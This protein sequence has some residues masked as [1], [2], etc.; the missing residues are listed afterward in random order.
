LS[1]FVLEI[2]DAVI[3]SSIDAQPPFVLVAERRETT[4]RVRTASPL[5]KGTIRSRTRGIDK[6]AHKPAR[7]STCNVLYP[8]C[9][10]AIISVTVRG[11]SS[12]D[13]NTTLV[14]KSGSTSNSTARIVVMTAVGIEV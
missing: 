12:V 7:P 2:V 9:R 1:T 11:L 3:R 6:A 4:I 10:Y 8:V 14:T 13:T 5:V